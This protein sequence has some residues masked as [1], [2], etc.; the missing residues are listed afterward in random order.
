M[1][2][3]KMAKLQCRTL[4]SLVL[5]Y[6]QLLMNIVSAWAY[7]RIWIIRAHCWR[8]KNSTACKKTC[9]SDSIGQL[10]YLCLHCLIELV[11]ALAGSWLPFYP[12]C[13]LFHCQLHVPHLVTTTP[14]FLFSTRICKMKEKNRRKEAYRS[15]LD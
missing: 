3:C 2:H 1:Q 11:H 15:F 7:E 14:C 5:L 6:T 10:L 9:I 8:A 12:G 13:R 4:R